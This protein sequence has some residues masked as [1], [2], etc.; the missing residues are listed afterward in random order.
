MSRF[1]VL[2]CK[3]ENLYKFMN[4]FP[5]N[6]VFL[7][8]TGKTKIIYSKERFKSLVQIIGAIGDEFS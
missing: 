4:F 6:S 1:S 8:V 5:T 7:F 3:N 2:L